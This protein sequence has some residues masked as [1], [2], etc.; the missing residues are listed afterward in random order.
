MVATALFT[1]LLFS[2][3]PPKDLVTYKP[4]TMPIIL[5]AP[6]GGSKPV[7][8]VEIRT[9][10]TVEKNIG[11]KTNF[12]FAFDRNTD[13][14]AIEVADAIEKKTGLRP[15][16]V[17]AHFSR[18]Y[19]DAN[20]PASDGYESELVKP[21]YDEYHGDIEKSRRE[22]LEKWKTGMLI[23]LHGQGSKKDGIFRGTSDLKTVKHLIDSKGRDALFGPNSILGILQSKGATLI[24][25]TEDTESKENPALNGGWTVRHYGS[26][27][28]G[29]FDAL[30]LETGINYRDL[31]KSKT[32]EDLSDAIIAFYKAFLVPRPVSSDKR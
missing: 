9:G 31:N 11:A 26:M 15:Y 24:P 21:V 3:E 17:V 13:K 6:H 19:I 28:G 16:L 25:T 7:P 30:Q 4:G 22:I 12:S 18:K 32:V 29:N 10:N 27:E 2:Q 14:L 23:D 5:T 1:A 20:R 8:G